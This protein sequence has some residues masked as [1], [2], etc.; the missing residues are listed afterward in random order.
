MSGGAPVWH[1]H[2]KWKL[3]KDGV[4]LILYLSSDRV[5]QIADIIKI[6]LQVYNFGAKTKQPIEPDR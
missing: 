1:I 5:D 4:V 6:Y 2:V 3:H